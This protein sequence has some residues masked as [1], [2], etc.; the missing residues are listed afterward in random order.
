M[1]FTVCL[2]REQMRAGRS[3]V[4]ENPVASMAWHLVPSMETL[5]KATGVFEVC[6]YQCAVWLDV[7]FGLVWKRTRFVTNCEA[8]VQKLLPLQCDHTPARS[9]HGRI[10]DHCCL[11]SLPMATYPRSEERRI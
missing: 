9:L 5:R 1:R 8:V 3:F 6:M 11:W 10:Q 4:I 7:G 2:A